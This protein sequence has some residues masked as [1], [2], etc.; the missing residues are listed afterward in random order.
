MSD[1]NSMVMSCCASCGIAEIDDIKLK[2]CSACDLVR[3]C[4]DACQ[5]DNRSEHEEECKKRA[6]ELRDELLFKQPESSHLGDCPICCVPLPIDISKTLI[7][8][9]CSMTICKGCSYAYQMRAMEER[10]IGRLCAFCRESVDITKE[11]SYKL[12]MK[13]VE[14]NDP[15]ALG[16]QGR[17]EYDE[18][19]YSGAF[20]YWTRAADSGDVDAHYRL[21]FLYLQGDG[22]EQDREKLM[23]HAEEAAIAG[24]PEARYLLGCVDSNSG[25]TDRAVKHWIIAAAHGHDY[26]T[27][28]LM[29]AFKEG[30]ISKEDLAATLRTHQAAVDA[31]K[32]PHREAEEEFRR[33]CLR[34][35]KT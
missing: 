20:E 5:L 2:E 21:A 32:S 33:I 1:D 35:K 3:Y 31:T 15:F 22:V 18:G 4:S 12:R 26:S 10:K 25:N 9:C 29:V 24:H 30:L 28:E 7:A 19:S 17:E 27:K 16:Q 8:S 11:Q 14:A 34:L 23:Y 13:R 6:A